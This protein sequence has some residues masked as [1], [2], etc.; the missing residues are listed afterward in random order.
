MLMTST[1]VPSLDI[2]LQLQ[3]QVYNSLL[4]IGCLEGSTNLTCSKTDFPSLS[5]NSFLPHFCTS[6][7]CSITHIIA[8][9]RNLWEV[10]TIPFHSIP[11]FKSLV[12]KIDFTC[13]G[14]SP[15][16]LPLHSPPII[17]L[18]CS[19]Y[20]CLPFCFP[21]ADFPSSQQ[22][23]LYAY[24]SDHVTSHPHLKQT[25]NSSHV[26]QSPTGTD[27]CMIS[28]LSSLPFPPH[29]PQSLWSS[30]FLELF[31]SWYFHGF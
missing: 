11:I 29:C 13:K 5:P 6:I 19:T 16:L 2:F 3:N 14:I 8:Q 26:L 17:S 22:R 4:L 10:W 18:S 9:V 12:S 24:T 27:L 21:L 15:L 23:D 28:L 7:S 30:L 31:F 25:Q 20:L 1:R